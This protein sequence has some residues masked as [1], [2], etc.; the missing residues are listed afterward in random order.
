MTTKDLLD[1]HVAMSMAAQALMARKNHDYAGQSG[2]TPFA[3]FEV[4]EALG[5]TSTERGILVRMGD[6]FKRLIEY[7]NN[8]TFRVRDEGL[9]DTCL[10][11][12]NYTVI[13]AAWLSTKKEMADVEQ[14][15]IDLCPPADA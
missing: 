3:N 5:I 13:L 10:D 12:I 1:K 14:T 4:A 7:V 15:G 8:G 9:E 2:S 11:L 6:K